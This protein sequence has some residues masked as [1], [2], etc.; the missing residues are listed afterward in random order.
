[1]AAKLVGAEHV[2]TKPMPSTASEDFSCMLEQH[3][4]AYLRVGQGGGDQGRNLHNPNYD[5]N[6]AILPLGASL[7][8]S[9][10]M[11]ALPL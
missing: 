8:A 2:I 10:A 11:D 6:D 5:F 4:G 1:M 7:L 3:P 9:L